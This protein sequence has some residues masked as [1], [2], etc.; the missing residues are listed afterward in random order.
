MGGDGGPANLLGWPSVAFPI[1]FE[2]G[3]PIGGQVIS[4]AFRENV[5]L[6]VSKAYQEKTGHHK[7]HPL[8]G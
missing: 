4:P 1:G 7:I 3:S 2:E 5:S 8:T 6:S